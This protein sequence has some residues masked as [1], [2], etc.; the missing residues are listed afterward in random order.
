MTQV[1]REALE[2]I[3][4]PPV[5]ARILERALYVAGLDHVPEDGATLL[6][7]VEDHLAP[8]AA[9][10]VGE[11]TAD[12]LVGQL[13][14]IIMLADNTN[15]PLGKEIS[16]VR[17]TVGADGATPWMDATLAMGESDPPDSTPPPF[18]QR[19][20]AGDYDALDEDL[21]A[22]DGDMEALS[23][24]IELAFQSAFP[25]ENASDVAFA[26]EELDII[27]DDSVAA[28]DAP[29]TPAPLATPESAPAPAV[30]WPDEEDLPYE[31]LAIS[32]AHTGGVIHTETRRPAATAQPV[33]EPSAEKPFPYAIP[34]PGQPLGGT[35]PSLIA[36][37]AAAPASAL[38]PATP[39]DDG[40]AWAHAKGSAWGDLPNRPRRQR[41]DATVQVTLPI[42]E[43]AR[44]S[45]PVVKFSGDT[46]GIRTSSQRS[47]VVVIASRDGEVVDALDRE[48][49]GRAR[50][51]SVDDSLALFDLLAEPNNGVGLVILDCRS[52]SVQPATVAAMAP[53]LPPNARVLLWGGQV[54]PAMLELFSSD[55]SRW[56]T[57]EPD[58]DA[59]AVAQACVYLL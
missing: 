27:I 35:A 42:P 54:D 57:V 28:S 5:R 8:S 3:A 40:P 9:A 55:A 6:R 22:L 11:E 52:P 25:K 33:T 50:L 29:A 24:D 1:V 7:F 47:A 23:V 46:S 4:A 12:Q 36:S 10:A 16:Q 34:R 41:S 37:H 58:A 44:R 49:N 39:N 32:D 38:K 18:V 13:M 21:S 45:D 26:A 53:D 19:E 17:R 48:L 15:A 43:E 14:P 59:A 2:G 31:H 51:R 20:D 56:T 30:E